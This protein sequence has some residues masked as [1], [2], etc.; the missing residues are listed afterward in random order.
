MRFNQ[1]LRAIGGVSQKMLT[2]QLR[3]LQ[4][5]GLVNRI[6]YEEIPPRVEYSLTE[7]DNSLNPLF[8]SIVHWN[9]AHAETIHNARLKYDQI[10]RID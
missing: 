8:D 9:N 10:N 4:R 3:E 1:L 7:L 2:Q 6:Q 5:D